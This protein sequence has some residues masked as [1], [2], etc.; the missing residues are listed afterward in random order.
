M[1]YAVGLSVTWLA[2]LGPMTFGIAYPMNAGPF[3]EEEQF[4]FELG[5]TF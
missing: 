5:R 3:E 4:Q 1:V 2:G